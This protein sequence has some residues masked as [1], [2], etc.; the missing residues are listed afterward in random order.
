MFFS[1][2]LLRLLT[3]MSAI[4][5]TAVHDRGKPATVAM[6]VNKASN[7]TIVSMNFVISYFSKPL[8]LSIAAT[9]PPMLNMIAMIA[10]TTCGLVSRVCMRSVSDIFYS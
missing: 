6:M 3:N 5:T 10:A 2:A 8:I 9:Y 1:I 7:R 4:A